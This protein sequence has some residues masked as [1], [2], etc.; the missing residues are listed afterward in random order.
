MG[1]RALGRR[2]SEQS[3]G[4]GRPPRA[5]GG[6]ARFGRT[7]V[8][9]P[10]SSPPSCTGTPIVRL[11]PALGEA[12]SP[13]EV[14]GLCA[15]G[16]RPRTGWIPRPGLSRLGR[17]ASRSGGERER[18]AALPTQS[19]AAEGPSGCT[20]R[21]P[22]PGQDPARV[23]GAAQPGRQARHGALGRGVK[24]LPP[25]EGG[26]LGERV[27]GHQGLGFRNCPSREGPRERRP[28]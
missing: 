14:P 25:L 7:G 17:Q 10:C 22:P 11:S 15:P 3:G 1:A 20:S 8:Q 6:S 23:E 12:R 4:A 24:R 16:S 18:E 19:P 28:S 9:L 5:R 2:A 13:G 21:P 26:S 27:P